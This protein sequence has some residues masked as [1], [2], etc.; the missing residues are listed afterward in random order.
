MCVVVLINHSNHA[1]AQA[2]SPSSFFSVLKRMRVLETTVVH[3][4]HKTQGRAEAMSR[5]AAAAKT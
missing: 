5:A 3:V 4:K 2:S 1:R